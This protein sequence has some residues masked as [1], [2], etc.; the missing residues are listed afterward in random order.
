M[1]DG[2][3]ET[4]QEKTDRIANDPMIADMDLVRTAAE[5][6][7][8]AADREQ[9]EIDQRAAKPGYDP[10]TGITVEYQTTSFAWERFSMY[11]MSQTVT[12]TSLGTIK[13]YRYLT[14]EDYRR[15][16][17]DGPENAFSWGMLKYEMELYVI[18]QKI[19]EVKKDWPY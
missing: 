1:S 10:E 19:E 16:I 12:G 14:I 5:I 13:R 2:M 15:R 7:S 8:R 11:R 3:E 18:S 4:V 6:R 17:G 9:W